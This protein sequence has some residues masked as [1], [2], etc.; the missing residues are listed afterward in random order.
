MNS[1]Y[2]KQK[3]EEE[4]EFEIFKQQQAD[5]NVEMIP[6]SRDPKR[7]LPKYGSD[8]TVIVETEAPLFDQS[9][10]EKLTQPLLRTYSIE[11]WQQYFGNGEKVGTLGKVKIIHHPDDL[12]KKK[13]EPIQQSF[14]D[15]IEKIK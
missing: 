5:G 7:E 1:N 13:A 12:K 3:E 11:E 8:R 2:L 15:R 6:C 9:T 10:G 4:R 14:D